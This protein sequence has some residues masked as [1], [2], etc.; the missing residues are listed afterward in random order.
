M[1]PILFV[2]TKILTPDEM[3]DFVMVKCCYCGEEM[4]CPRSMLKEGM[5]H[6]CEFC[7]DVMSEGMAD[8]QIKRCSKEE[9][10]LSDYYKDI[11]DMALTVLLAYPP[12]EV[13]QE[14]M[15]GVSKERIKRGSFFHG[16][17]AAFDLILHTAGPEMLM[18]IK[19]SPRFDT[20]CITE[21]KIAKMQKDAQR[22]AKKLMGETTARNK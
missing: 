10:L 17:V 13:L 1:R 22:E 20:L 6:V 7:A 19:K 4:D 16:A 21:E 2:E 3:K 11:D 14:S 8:E 12:D 18:D 5:K 9:R 15:K